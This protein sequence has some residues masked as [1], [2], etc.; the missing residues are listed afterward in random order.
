MLSRPFTNT[1]VDFAGP[2]EIK[3]FTGRYCKITK[4]Y[5]CLFV[6]FATK[7]IHLEAVSD[8]STAAFLAALARFVAR[9]GC[10]SAMYS[11]NGRNFVGAAR[12]I[13]ENFG[14]R[15]KDLKDEAVSKYG[16]QRLSW[17]FIPAGAPHMGGLWESGVKSFKGH[18][19]KVSGQLKYT[20]EELS[21]LLATI[22]ACLNSRPLGALP[23]N[24]DDLQALTPAHF[25]IGSSMLTPATPEEV[26]CA[27]SVLNR[28]RK[29]KAINQEVCRRWKEEY[30]LE[31]HKRQKWKTPQVDLIEGDIVVLK[32]E[33][34]GSTDWRLGRVTKTYHG[35]DGRVR[36][37]DL[38]TQSG[39]ITRPIHKLVLLPR[40][41]QN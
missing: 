19:R 29:L 10:P 14:K 38:R 6:C 23:D 25:L 4:G 5:V 32:N 35:S 12:E 36:V 17:H 39:T 28:W 24:V 1:G 33:S 26:K 2:L 7:A 30:L 8:L 16:H 34:T 13:D 11:D 18:F 3:S 41:S 40:H 37:V 22:E 9:R 31:L 27:G 20:F 21:T 15:V